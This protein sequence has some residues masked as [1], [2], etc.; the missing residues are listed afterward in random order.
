MKIINETVW[1]TKELRV[2]IKRVASEELD[3]VHRKRAVIHVQYR[4]NNRCLGRGELGRSPQQAAMTIWI[5]VDRPEHLRRVGK[6]WCGK[7][8]CGRTYRIHLDIADHPYVPIPTGL[9]GPQFAHV[10]AHEF[11]HNLGRQHRQMHPKYLRHDYIPWSWANDIEVP[12]PTRPS[13]ERV[14]EKSRTHV[15]TMLRKAETRAKRAS[16]LLKKWQRRMRAVLRRA[17]A[18]KAVKDGPRTDSPNP[19]KTTGNGTTARDHRG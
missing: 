14:L 10:V 8:G 4:G 13:P 2:I 15:T 5:Y 19:A 1:P 18:L 11:Q 6:G 16:R 7:E 12:I 9:N 3:A 17:A